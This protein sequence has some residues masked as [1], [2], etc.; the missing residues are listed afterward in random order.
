MSSELLFKVVA[1]A[2]CRFHDQNNIMEDCINAITNQ[3][4]NLDDKISA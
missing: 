1:H 2:Y 4:K 3:I